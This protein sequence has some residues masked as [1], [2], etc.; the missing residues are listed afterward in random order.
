MCLF[1]CPITG[2]LSGPIPKGPANYQFL[3]QYK[4]QP[5]KTAPKVLLAQS[6]L[7]QSKTG[8]PLKSAPIFNL[9]APNPSP[10][11]YFSS[12]K[13][14]DFGANPVIN[15]RFLYLMGKLTG[16]YLLFMSNILSPPNLFL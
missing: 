12:P 1:M 9:S 7:D 6:N 10:I 5:N 11:P 15:L 14:F 8:S 4:T 2:P 3:L 16:V 13:Q